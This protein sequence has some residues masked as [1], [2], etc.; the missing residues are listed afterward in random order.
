MKLHVPSSSVVFAALVLAAC[1]SSAPSENGETRQAV[2]ADSPMASVRGPGGHH[3]PPHGP[4]R[5]DMLLERLDADGNGVVEAAEI[6]AFLADADANEDGRLTLD[7]LKAHGEAKRQAHFAR[8]DKN[9]DGSLT[10]DEIGDEHWSRLSLADANQDGKLTRAELDAAHAA[11]KL[12]PPMGPPPNGAR[13]GPPPGP[14][15]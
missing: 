2:A 5:P 1:S 8:M 7:E 6:P 14:P 12:R 15:L 10:Q 4:P 11:G 3:R 9:Q 13:R